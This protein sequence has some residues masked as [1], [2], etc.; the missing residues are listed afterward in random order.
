MVNSSTCIDSSFYV[1]TEL[2]AA[3]VIMFSLRPAVPLSHVACQ[4]A[5]F[6]L[7]TN[8]ERVSMKV[9]EVITTINRYKVLTITLLQNPPTYISLSLFSPLETLVPPL[10]SQFLDH[11]H[12]LI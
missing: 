10:L 11:P 8:T 4:H 2:W 1:S 7:R 9:G 3:K 6:S 12:L 5:I